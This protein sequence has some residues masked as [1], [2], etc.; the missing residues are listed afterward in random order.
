T[1][2]TYDGISRRVWHLDYE[3]PYDGWPQIIEGI[4][5]TSG[6][7]GFI[8][9]YWEGWNELLCFSVNGEEVWRSLRDTCFV[10]TD[11]CATVGINEPWQQNID[12]SCYP[13]PLPPSTNFA[14][15]INPLHTSSNSIA[16]FDLCGREV[17]FKTFHENSITINSPANQGIYVL[18]IFA[19]ES[20]STFK[21]IVSN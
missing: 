21:I 13:N 12:V 9:P 10:I 6:L 1:I 11:S 16:L 2:Q 19:N 3:E 5:S 14:I 4:G 20:Y 18:K 15:E 17:F 7:I 8:E